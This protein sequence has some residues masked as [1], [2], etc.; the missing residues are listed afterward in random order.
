MFVSYSN[1]KYWTISKRGHIKLACKRCPI[2]LTFPELRDQTHNLPRPST[3]RPKGFSCEHPTKHFKNWPFW[4]SMCRHS[5]L[6]SVTMIWPRQSVTIQPGLNLC[7]LLAG[8]PSYRNRTCPVLSKTNTNLV[9]VSET[10]ISPL[11]FSDK[12]NSEELG[13]KMRFP[14]SSISISCTIFSPR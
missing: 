2:T 4:S 9:S 14:C 3:L 12:Y 5:F 11:L 1:I 10:Q 8:V 13:S 7:L 6:E